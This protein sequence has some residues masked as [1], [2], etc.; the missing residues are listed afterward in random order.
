MEG[1]SVALVG[2]IM[3]SRG[4]GTRL[5]H[6]PDTAILAPGLAELLA[7]ADYRIG[8]LECP[9]SASAVVRREGLF[10]A[11]PAT[12]AQLRQFDLLTLANNHIHDCG[13][14]GVDDTVAALEAAGYAHAGLCNENGQTSRFTCSVKGMR[15]AVIAMARPECIPVPESG[16]YSINRTDAAGT[17]ELVTSARKSHDRVITIIHGGNEMIPEPP[18]TLISLAHKLVDAG[19]DIVVT[20]HPH[21]LGGMESYK[22][23]L[24]FYSLGD[25]IFDGQSELRRRGA[26]LTITFGQHQISWDMTYTTI[27]SE[28]NVGIADID[29]ARKAREGFERV[30]REVIAKGYESRYDRL[31]RSSMLRFQLDRLSFLLRNRGISFVLSFVLLKAKLIPHYFNSMFNRLHR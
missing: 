7:R 27:E 25:F 16:R 10:R 19:A 30:S 29:S 21:V 13:R 3:L 28:L 23:A 9:I 18:P 5:A 20:H 31:Y 22:D 11:D 12:L 26:V 4:V 8:N 14:Q 6:K 1:P 15:I 2:D 17:I 24:I